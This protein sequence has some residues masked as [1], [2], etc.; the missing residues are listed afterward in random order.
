MTF[1]P[2]WSYGA[3]RPETAAILAN[4]PAGILLSAGLQRHG[5]LPYRHLRF[6]VLLGEE[7]G[8]RPAYDFVLAISQ[9]S[10]RPRVPA[11]HVAGRIH[12]EDGVILDIF[13]Q[14]A[15]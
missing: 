5:Q 11:L 15:K 7:K 6:D 9:Q 1:I 12:E 14:Q 3:R 10:L 8:S 13:D 2:Q 4:M